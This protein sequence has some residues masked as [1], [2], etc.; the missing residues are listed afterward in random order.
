MPIMEAKPILR[1]ASRHG[2]VR[3]QAVKGIIRFAVTLSQSNAYIFGAE[4]IER[5]QPFFR[6]TRFGGCVLCLERPTH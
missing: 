2:N 5:L 1:E 3:P 4:I 6:L